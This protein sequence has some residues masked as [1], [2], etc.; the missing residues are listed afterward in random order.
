MTSDSVMPPTSARTTWT[1]TSSCGSLAIS[2]WKA[3]SEPD[4]S[5]LRTRLSS[6]SVAAAGVVEDLLERARRRWRRASASVLRRLP[7]S[8]A[9]WRALRSFSTTRTYSPASGTESK[10]S[11]STGS[12]G[13][14]LLDL[15]AEVVVHRADAAP[16]G[17]GDDGVADLQRA[18]LDEHGDDG[19]A[20]RVELGLDDHARR[21]GV[22]VG[23]ELLDLGQQEDRLEQ[24]VEVRSW[25]WPRRR[26]T[27]CRR[28]TPRAGGRAGSSR[29]G[30]GRAARP[31]CRSC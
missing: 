28:P 26:R 18:A 11:T 25:P 31:P 21:L 6:C 27:S 20:A 12:D 1:W 24:V 30:R 3:S 22:R 23:L 10:P 2:S 17:A 13:V 8:L 5:A 29:C 19:A 15:A 9:S 14:G 16:V 4:T 7:R